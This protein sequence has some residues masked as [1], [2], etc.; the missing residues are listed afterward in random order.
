MATLL[1]F[2]S[3]QPVDVPDDQVTSAVASGRFGLPKGAVAVRDGKGQ[4][5]ELDADDAVRAFAAGDFRFE[6][7][8]ERAE[9]DAEAKFGSSGGEAL[10][11]GAGALRGASF[12][13]SDMA[14]VETGLAKPSTLKGLEDVNPTASGG[15]ELAG[16]VG[17]LL[18]PGAGEVSVA[19][20]SG[21]AAQL[22]ER[23]AAKALGKSA[24]KVAGKALTK[25]AGGAVEGALYGTGHA[26]S[27][28][29]LGDTELTAEKLLAGAGV[30]AL[31]GAGGAAGISLVGE[32]AKAGLRTG[33]KLLGEMP[34][35]SGALSEFAQRR[36]VKAAGAIQSNLNKIDEKK[37]LEIGQDLLDTGIVNAKSSQD[38]IFQAVVGKRKETGKKIGEL[39]K[40]ADDAGAKFDL[41]P[42]L[43]R[44]DEMLQEIALDPALRKEARELDRLLKGYAKL[45]ED[46]VGFAQANKLKSNL[47]KTV[48]KWV[49]SDAKL[50]SAKKMQG[51]LD[52]EIESQLGAA[53]SKLDDFKEAKRLYGNLSEAAKWGRRSQAANLGNRFFSITDQGLGGLAGAAGV[54]TSGPAGILAGVATA[55]GNKVLRERAPQVLADFASRLGESPALKTLA[56]SFHAAVNKTLK[57]T[58]EAFGSYGG[59]L[60]NAAAHGADDLLATHAALAQSDPAYMKAVASAGFRP[61]TPE[62]AEG[63]TR[64]ANQ[65]SK[66]QKMVE[67][68]DRRLTAAVDGFL[69]NQKP[70]KGPG[71]SA[72]AIRKGF[73]VTSAELARLATDPQALIDRFALNPALADAAPGVATAV[74]T[75]ATR[76]VQFLH[77]KAPKSPHAP[78]MPAL[79]K[80]WSPTDAQLQTWSRHVRAVQSPETVLEDLQ[81]GTASKE[82]VEALQAVYPKLAGD[83]KARFLERMATLDGRLP[84]RKRAALTALFGAGFDGPSDGGK[85]VLLQAHRT[86]MAAEMAK[87]RG[88]G[89]TKETRAQTNM[90]TSAQRLERRGA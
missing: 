40:E 61:E 13:I 59:V 56:K 6:T 11:A 83:V 48:K 80:P 51:F 5:F 4:A 54:A 74:T 35:L 7:G 31:L 15:G 82:A 2:A 76:A 88:G 43:K 14:L 89:S 58:P 71:L 39:L 29:Y 66:V 90:E 65:L 25:A 73:S 36:S 16:A 33:A 67:E 86:A 60:A 17:S 1:D 72:S 3:G 30:G 84:W 55:A 21:K 77:E 44:G 63:A 22:A 41:A 9:R 87:Q 85:A 23:A 34:D 38:D 64:R 68:H 46:G 26:V 28:S 27:E 47:Q 42:V 57:Q 78:N 37:A 69:T 19:K 12:G 81:R 50:E 8:A 49:D 10:A 18:I 62:E 20:A 75:A 45:S 52:D 32:G 79:A 70:G 53:T 24:Q